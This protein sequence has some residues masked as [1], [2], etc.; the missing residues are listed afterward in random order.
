[1]VQ[2]S[3]ALDVLAKP[4]FPARLDHAVVVG[5]VDSLTVELFAN[6]LFIAV[7]RGVCGG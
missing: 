1:M 3:Y 7:H 5:L 2:W 6:G 4:L